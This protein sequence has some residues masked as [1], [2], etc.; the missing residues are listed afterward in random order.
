MQNQIRDVVTGRRLLLLPPSIDEATFSLVRQPASAAFMKKELVRLDGRMK[1]TLRSIEEADR[2]DLSKAFKK[3][4]AT[5]YDAW[6]AYRESYAKF[7]AKLLEVGATTAS[8]QAAAEL[9]FH[10]EGIYYFERLRDH[11]INRSQVPVEAE[12]I[13]S[14][15]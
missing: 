8:D 2:E 10:I 1:E 9:W 15:D 14:N 12:R 7:S 5:S 4:F 11:E 3:G 13:V 6:K